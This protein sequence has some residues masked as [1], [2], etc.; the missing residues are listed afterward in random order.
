MVCI[1]KILK[2]LQDL[3]LEKSETHNSF[4]FTGEDTQR[5]QFPLPLNEENQLEKRKGKGKFSILSAMH[6]SKTLNG[7]HTN[8]DKNM[9]DPK[10]K[11]NG[12]F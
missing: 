6:I 5:K 7:W 3:S 11:G 1:Y 4:K 9:N 2:A 8:L 12:K 10:D